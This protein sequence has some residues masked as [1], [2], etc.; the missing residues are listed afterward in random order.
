MLSKHYNQPEATTL[1]EVK[2]IEGKL[3]EWHH[4]SISNDCFKC[5]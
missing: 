2:E 4:W 5:T 3:K 1:F